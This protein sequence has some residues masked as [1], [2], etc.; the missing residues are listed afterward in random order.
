M[1]KIKRGNLKLIQL[2]DK[3]KILDEKEKEKIQL[4]LKSVMRFLVS[5]KIT[6]NAS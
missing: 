3:I 5:N 6:L 4:K 1:D 2:E